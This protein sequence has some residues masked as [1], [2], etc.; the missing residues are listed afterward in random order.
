MLIERRCNPLY[1][2]TGARVRYRRAVTSA[3]LW[4]YH[5]GLLSS[6]IVARM[7]WRWQKQGPACER[8]E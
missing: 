8:P 2:G 5:R 6:H 3:A 4:C 7:L 1:K